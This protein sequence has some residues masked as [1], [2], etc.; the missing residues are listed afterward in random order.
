MSREI[1]RAELLAELSAS[2]VLRPSAR[3]TADALNAFHAE[4]SAETILAEALAIHE[5]GS[6]AM[7]SSFG[8]DS[9]VLLH[10]L[11]RV[12]PATPVLML[13]TGMLFPETLAYQQELAAALGLAD[14][15]LVRPDAAEL[16]R[17]DADG[18][19]NER[20]PNT[21]CDL[22]KTRPLDRALRPFDAWITGRKRFQ[23]A[24]RSSLMPFEAEEGTTRMKVNPLAGWDGAMLK[25]YTDRH[26]LPRHPLVAKG[27][28][29]IGCAPCTTP[30]AEGEDPRAGRWRGQ[31]KVECGIHFDGK[32]WV[33][34]AAGLP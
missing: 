16:A 28:P 31:D 30:V 24:T 20:L 1:T 9:A 4:S 17:E 29:S 25:S 33:R 34:T 21:C 7:V 10:M 5:P 22:R 23:A 12:E 11:S 26:A 19:L 13:E 14:V 2:R 27:Y 18:R 6:V 32:N 3:A 15:R 8:A